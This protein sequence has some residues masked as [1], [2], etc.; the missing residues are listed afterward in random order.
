M[1][2]KLPAC[3][4][5]ACRGWCC[6]TGSAWTRLGSTSE[7][8]PVPARDCQKL[9][10]SQWGTV[11]RWGAGETETGRLETFPQEDRWAAAQAARGAVQ[12]PSLPE[13]PGLTPWL[14]VL[15][16][17]SCIRHLLS[18]LLIWIILWHHGPLNLVFFPLLMMVSLSLTSRE[19]YL[20]SHFSITIFYLA[21]IFNINQ[22]ESAE[23]PFQ[24]CI[25][26]SRSLRGTS[27]SLLL[28]AVADSFFHVRAG[29]K[30]FLYLFHLL[31]TLL[32]HV[33]PSYHPRRRRKK[34]QA[35]PERL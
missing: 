15:G 4:S 17:M 34:W 24:E 35:F 25:S 5:A 19:K 13:Q 28:T 32:L 30:R 6:R 22:L 14:T 18:S 11:G 8:L 29:R 26:W 31:F 27:S 16:E 23:D 21:S 1:G 10:S 33:L 2:H 12:A 7:Q 9:G 3:S 20:T